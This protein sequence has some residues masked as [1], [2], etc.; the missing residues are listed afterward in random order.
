LQELKLETEGQRAERIKEEEDDLDTIESG[1]LI[2]GVPCMGSLN[3]TLDDVKRG[4][5]GIRDAWKHKEWA[6]KYGWDLEMMARARSVYYKWLVR[7][8]G[9][10][11]TTYIE[12]PNLGESFES[13]PQFLEACAMVSY[14]ARFADTDTDVFLV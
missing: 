11:A 3:L 13:A 1:R 5:E 6:R 2:E 12:P 14:C 8:T 9:T 7:H 10:P 4:R